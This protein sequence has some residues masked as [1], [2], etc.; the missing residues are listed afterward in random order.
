MHHQHLAPMT[1]ETHTYTYLRQD[2]LFYNSN[3]VVVPYPSGSG[4]SQPGNGPPPP[5]PPPPSGPGG[6]PD[7][8]PHIPGR[9][10]NG[11]PFHNTRFQ[12]YFPLPYYVNIPIQH[13][14][15]DSNIKIMSSFDQVPNI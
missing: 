7:D 1:L 2:N 11:I 15:T 3:G 4:P 13:N 6:P 10:G 14:S 9:Q 5:P 8:R 12:P